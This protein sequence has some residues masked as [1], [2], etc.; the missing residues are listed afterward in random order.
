MNTKE[1]IKQLIK[2]NNRQT[3]LLESS[4]AY[5]DLEKQKAQI[6]KKLGR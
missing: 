2:L 5:K 3:G 1:L 4:E 6:W